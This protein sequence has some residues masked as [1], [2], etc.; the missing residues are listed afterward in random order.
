M[1]LRRFIDHLFRRNAAPQP[2]A[3]LEARDPAIITIIS[4]IYSTAPMT[5]TGDAVYVTMTSPRASGTGL[6]LTKSSGNDD[7]DDD[8]S[9][10]SK[11][12]ANPTSSAS[13]VTSSSPMTTSMPPTTS[14]SAT[15]I[16]ATVTPSATAVA[17]SG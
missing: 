12:S 1:H 9:R 10:S 2:A 14:S 16:A 8:N 6:S 13:K 3:N 7:D 15:I 11:S 4:V 5:F 17:K